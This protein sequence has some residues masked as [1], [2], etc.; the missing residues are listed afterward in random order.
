MWPHHG[1]DRISAPV[2]APLPVVVIQFIC[3]LAPPVT[4][5]RLTAQ[6][7]R[8]GCSAVETSRIGGKDLA[9]DPVEC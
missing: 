8:R 5:F 9:G 4:P 3:Y 2:M 6:T 7:S 1:I